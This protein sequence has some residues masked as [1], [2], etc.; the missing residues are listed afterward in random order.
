MVAQ[1]DKNL[2]PIIL[3][4]EAYITRCL[5]DHLL[6]AHTYRILTQANADEE[7]R[8]YDDDI[9]DFLALRSRYLPKKEIQYISNSLYV[10]DKW[11]Y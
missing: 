10:A 9:E 3:D 6:N 5:K 7:F 11:H 2:S 8:S 4:R 1:T